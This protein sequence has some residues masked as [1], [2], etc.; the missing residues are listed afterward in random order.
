VQALGGRTALARATT[1]VLHGTQTTRDLV[2]VPITVQ[3]KV[4]GEYRIDVDSKPQPTSRVFDG[5]N[6]WTVA[7]GNARDLE[8]ILAAQVS[9]PSDFGLAL[10]IRQRYQALEAQRYGNIDGTDVIV[11]AARANP[12]VI[13]M[14]AFERQSGLLKRR[15]IQT[16]TPYGALVEQVDYSDYRDA[17]GIKMPFQVKYTN[18]REA[19][20]EKFTDATIDAPVDASAFAKK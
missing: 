12:D 19:T 20:T 7:F 16:R 4:T 9:R 8:G 15:T 2:T 3:E 6:A 13:D 17:G 11:V 18:W 10:D 14:L 1:R 5:K